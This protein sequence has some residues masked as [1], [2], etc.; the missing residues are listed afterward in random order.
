MSKIVSVR[1]NESEA[2]ILNN[3][4]NFYG[5][6]VSSLLKKLAIEKLEDEYD[7]SII[8]EYEEAKKKGLVETRPA[9]EFFRDLGI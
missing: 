4:A 7:L 3:A 2:E 9:E 6:A 5:C 8:R 1:M